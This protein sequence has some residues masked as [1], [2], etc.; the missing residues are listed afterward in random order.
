VLLVTLNALFGVGFFYFALRSARRGWPFLRAG[1]LAV[2]TGASH[3]DFRYNV[4]HRR[5][6][7]EGGLFLIGG[8]LWLLASGGAL[9][10]ALYF[11]WQ[12]WQLAF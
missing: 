11:S 9:L 6:I 12:A 4:E 8:L 7:S 1:W 10:G 2:Q 3:P 5:T